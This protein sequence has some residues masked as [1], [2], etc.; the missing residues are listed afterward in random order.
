MTVDPR[1]EWKQIFNDTWRF[2]R[3]F[4]YDPNMHGVDWNAMRTRYGK[5]LDDAVTRW[6]VNFVIGELIAELTRRTRTAAAATRPR[7]AGRGRGLSRRRLGARQ[8]RLSHQEDHRRRAVGH[9]GAL[10]ARACRA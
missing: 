7:V 3:D 9:R 5:L 1:A 10:A 6:D 8:R 2:E 4:F